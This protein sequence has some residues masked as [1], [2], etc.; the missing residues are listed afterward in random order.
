MKGNAIVL[1]CMRLATFPLK[2]SLPNW[3]RKRGHL[4]VKA[5][6]RIFFL[7]SCMDANSYGSFNLPF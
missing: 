7:C 1:K 6:L 5:V 2:S 4:K 3:I